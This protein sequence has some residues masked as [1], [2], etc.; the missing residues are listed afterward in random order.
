[1]DLDEP[2]EIINCDY[3]GSKRKRTLYNVDGFYIVKCRDCSL[4]YTEN[5]ISQKELNQ[6]YSEKYFNISSQNKN[7]RGFEESNANLDRLNMLLTQKKQG[8]LLELGCGTGA[9]LSLVNNKFETFGIDISKSAAE[10]GNKKFGLNIEVGVLEDN[11]FSDKFFDI[12]V[13]WHLLEHLPKPYE[14]IK[15]INRILKKG[16][17][18]GIEVPNV[19]GLLWRLSRKKWKGGLHP[20][21]HRYHFSVGILKNILTSTGF[22]IKLITTNWENYKYDNSERGVIGMFK[23]FARANLNFLKRGPIIRVFAEKIADDKHQ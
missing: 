16:G 9:F 3:C 11:N 13:M 1:L 8:R 4:I 6:L 15:E 19:N 22:E 18:I 2:R 21:Y 17:I 12:I 7:V 10:F 23:N 20:K 5:P 14:S